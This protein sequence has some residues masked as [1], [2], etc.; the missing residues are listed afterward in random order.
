MNSIML[1]EMG[2]VLFLFYF[3]LS[4]F[5]IKINNFCSCFKLVFLSVCFV[6]LV[7][8]RRTTPLSNYFLGH[9]TLDLHCISQHMTYLVAIVDSTYRY[10]HWLEQKNKKTVDLFSQAVLFLYGC[11][12][13][14]FQET[15]Y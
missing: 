4:M 9:Q 11:L 14:V 15:L 2:M 7:E 5:L 13:Y 8:Q 6:V 1:I 12:Y 10:I 3:L